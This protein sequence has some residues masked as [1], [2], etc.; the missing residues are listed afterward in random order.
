[1]AAYIADEIGSDAPL[2]ETPEPIAAL[3]AVEIPAA[4]DGL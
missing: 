1:M 2:D 3:E 4:D